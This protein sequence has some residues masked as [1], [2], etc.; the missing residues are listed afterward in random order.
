MAMFIMVKDDDVEDDFN[1]DTVDDDVNV[2][3]DDR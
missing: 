3:H 1:D 2:E